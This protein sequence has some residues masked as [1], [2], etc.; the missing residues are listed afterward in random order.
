MNKPTKKEMTWF[1]TKLIKI[2]GNTDLTPNHIADIEFDYK[3][4][5]KQKSIFKKITTKAGAQNKIEEM[6]Y[7]IKGDYVFLKSLDDFD[8]KHLLMKT[9]QNGNI[10]IKGYQMEVLT[11][12]LDKINRKNQEDKNNDPINESKNIFKNSEDDYYINRGNAP[13]LLK[14]KKTALYYA[15]FDTLYSLASEGGT[16]AFNDFVR[17]VRPEIRRKLRH[18]DDKV[19]CRILRSYLTD[20]SNG[21]LRASEIEYTLFNGKPLIVCEPGIGIIFNNKK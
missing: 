12:Y 14:L 15:A 20:S 13:R 1:V 21:F 4:I 9:L 8:E 10:S 17:S 6:L 18:Q 16:V 5:L 7:L 2:R 3:D 19:V 11:A